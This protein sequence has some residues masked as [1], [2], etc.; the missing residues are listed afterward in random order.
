MVT[1]AAGATAPTL[2]EQ[3][4]A[5]RNER[6]GGAGEHPVVRKILERFPGA[7]IVDVRGPEA[8]PAAR[9]R[10]PATTRSA[11]PTRLTTTNCE[12]SAAM[13]DILGMMKKAQAVQAQLQ[14]AQ[15]ALARLDVE[16]QS[17]GG[18]VKVTLTGKGEMKARRHRSVAA[19]AR[20]Q[21]NGRGP[22]PGRLRRRQGQGRSPFGGEDAE[23]RRRPAIA[24]GHETAV[25]RPHVVERRRP[26]N[27][28]ADPA[29]GAP[30]GARAALG[31]ARGAASHPQARA[32]A[33]A[34]RRG[35]ARRPRADRRLLG[36][37]QC[38][39]PRPLH[40]LR[41]R[42]ARKRDA[43]GRRVGRRSLGARARAG[44]PRRAITCSAARCRRSTESGRKTSTSPASSRASPRAGCRR[45]CSPST[46]PSTA[47][48]PR[49]TSPNS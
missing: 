25:L 5:R 31:A 1:L 6:L 10:R 32:A 24:A 49:I 43:G 36:V 2:R 35:D 4:T 7:K 19:D 9:R 17:G 8:P 33:R 15:E 16:G 22:D 34:A 48:R 13:V 29:S 41:R 45:S 44:D 27:R 38:R 42:A 37:R 28:A 26:G 21:G 46:P 23:P 18:M 11:M 40:D 20:R 47:R 12:R 39:H 14:E 3:A 30:A